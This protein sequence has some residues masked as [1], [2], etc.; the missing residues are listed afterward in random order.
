MPRKPHHVNIIATQYIAFIELL[1]IAPQPP[2]LNWGLPITDQVYPIP[3]LQLLETAY[4]G[5]PDSK[6]RHSCDC[7]G[8][9]HDKTTPCNL[10]L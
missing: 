7:I 6:R 3:S 2:I 1:Q 4:I 9:M 5:Y 8:Q 10:E